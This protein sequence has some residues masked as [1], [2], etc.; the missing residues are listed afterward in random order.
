MSPDTLTGSPTSPARRGSW[1]VFIHK[2]PPQPSSLRVSIWRRLKEV[3]A[4]GLQQGVWLLAG[5]P[6]YKEV[7]SEVADRIREAGGD[8]YIFEATELVATRPIEEYANADRDAEYR[9]FMDSCQAFLQEIQRETERK[10][11]TFAELEENEDN[12]QRLRRWLANIRRRDVFHAH[13]SDQAQAA[14]HAGQV[15]LEE[16]TA[17]VY[18]A[19]GL[20]AASD[21]GETGGE[22]S[23][24]GEGTGDDR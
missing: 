12:L 23:P 22:S 3:G 21:G 20:G 5:L 10:N 7:L 24:G 11:F 6:W 13:M 19:E 1:L 9:E 4:V 8:A 14:W 17:M 2:I 15:A 18:Q 16:F